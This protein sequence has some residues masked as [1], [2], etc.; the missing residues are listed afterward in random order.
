MIG[1]GM[2]A[3][4]LP[5]EFVRAR[6]GA[7]AVSQHIVDLATLTSEKMTE[8]NLSDLGGDAPRALTLMS[9]A[10]AS[11]AAAYGKAFELT[12]HLQALAKSLPGISSVTKQREGSE[13]VAIELSLVSEFIVYTQKVDAFLDAL[14]RAIRFNIEANRAAAA[15]A[16]D[17]VNT[18]VVSI[19]TL[20]KAFRE[21]IGIF[22]AS[23]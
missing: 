13:A 11:N 3:T 14:E 15:A 19:N 23:E 16:L 1:A 18:K 12:Q 10:R 2:A 5:Q 17:E 6:Q 21:A 22:D 8:V 4:R 7:A 9:D 20:N